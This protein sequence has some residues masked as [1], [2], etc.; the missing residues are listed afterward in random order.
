MQL[1]DLQR[2]PKVAEDVPSSSV[3]PGYE[4]PGSASFDRSAT[5]STQNKRTIQTR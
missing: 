3:N 1:H 2:N 5:F 4:S